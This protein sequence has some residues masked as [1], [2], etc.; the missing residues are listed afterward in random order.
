MCVFALLH[1]TV[2]RVFNNEHNSYPEM[3]VKQHLACNC[4]VLVASVDKRYIWASL[5]FLWYWVFRNIESN[6][7]KSAR[8]SVLHFL[9]VFDFI[10]HFYQ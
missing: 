9:P 8:Q 7:C 2:S 1:F 10:S 3:S 4:A 6:I 5:F